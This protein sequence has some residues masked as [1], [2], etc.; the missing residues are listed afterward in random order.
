MRSFDN[1]NKYTDNDNKPL[2]GCIMFMVNLG[3]TV[4][5]IYDKDGT[6]LNNPQLT[7]T[8]GRTQHQVFIEE[9]VIAYYYKYIGSGQWY[10]EQS[11]DPS[12]ITKWQLQYTSKSELNAL[13]DINTESATCVESIESLRNINPTNIPTINGV[14]V[15]T[16]LGYN[17][18]GDKEPINYIYKEP[19]D[20]IDDGGS[21]INSYVVSTGQ[22]IMV[23]PTEHCDSRH[24]GVFPQDSYNTDDQAYGITQLFNY[25]NTKGIRPFFNGSTDKAWFRYNNID[26]AVTE[27]D[28]TDYTKF[29]DTG[30]NTILGE[31]NGNPLFYN[32]NTTIN[33]STVKTSW[34]AK[35]YINAKKV[36]IDEVTNQ[37]VWQDAHIDV[38]ISPLYGYTFHHCT[39]EENGNI[40]TD[41][42]NKVFTRFVNCQLTERMFILEGDYKASFD[43]VQGSNFCISCQIDPDDFTHAMWLYKE[44][45][46]TME[47]N[48]IFN[49]R[50]YNIVGK[51][52]ESFDDN[53]VTAS[54]ITVNNLNND[55]TVKIEL[56]KL[57]NQ[58]SLVLQNAIG[59]YDIPEGL[60]VVIQDSDVKLDISNNVVVSLINSTVELNA[61]PVV[62]AGNHCE[63]ALKDSTLNGSVAVVECDNFTSW[64]SV[65]SVPIASRN[66]VIKDSQVNSELTLIPQDGLERAVSY[67][68]G[69]RFAPPYNIQRLVSKFIN[70]YIDNSIFNARLVIDAQF[71]VLPE[72]VIN[73]P[74][75]ED[76][77]DVLC[78]KLT[79]TNN[80]SSLTY[81]AW[82]IWPLANAWAHDNLHKYIF[83]NNKGGFAC[84]ATVNT[85]I[86]EGAVNIIEE[87]VNGS[88]ISRQ[89]F[90]ESTSNGVIM[91]TDNHLSTWYQTSLVE[92]PFDPLLPAYIDAGTKYFTTMKL[93]TIGNRDVSIDLSVE[94]TPD[95]SA[96]SYDIN[97]LGI[98]KALVHLTDEAE[99][100]P[101]YGYRLSSLG[102]YKVPDVR[103][104]MTLPDNG[105]IPKD[106]P[107]TDYEWSPTWQIRNFLLGYSTF[108]NNTT[109]NI[110]FR[111]LDHQS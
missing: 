30:D 16:L 28:A 86:V 56:D 15:I 1:W 70:A 45:R 19:Y 104:I 25:C 96:R 38:Q 33:A 49:Y 75:S 94:L 22:W 39:F 108:A 67:K 59:W 7:D 40:G 106:P 109:C 36:I 91:Q 35:A 105:Q 5:P 14:K 63:I 44:I 11:I 101:Y 87:E 53:K 77:E 107:V 12:D 32:S 27:I 60:T 18:V 37:K 10:T 48:Q 82:Y 79:I 78:D 99:I 34:K 89:V 4:A 24:F 57:P 9:D 72:H 69:Y 64:N 111:Q 100:Y 103:N 54:T 17:K 90:E 20:A 93:F 65:I 85:T 80:N 76:I 98:S 3:N 95:G 62:S 68:N 71:G 26:V 31:W 52:Y 42:A 84:T 29:Y 13:K 97:S 8:Y 43:Y 81:D 50:D 92:D 110:T 83:S 88:T 51:P 66:T 74:S 46:Q 6:A 21:I 55:G 73:P 2:H 47:P 58:T 23:Q 41:N 61:A 102:P